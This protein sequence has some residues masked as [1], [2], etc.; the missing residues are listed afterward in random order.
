V[1]I[2]PSDILLWKVD[3]ESSLVDRIVGWAERKSGQPS[4][5]GTQFYHVGIIGPD[6]LHYYDSAPGGIKNSIISAIWPDHLQVYRF[7]K[8]VTPDQ[9]KLMWS[10]ANSQIGVGYNW[11]GAL[12]LGWIEVAG[13]PF[14][15]EFVWRVC[16]YAG[17]VICPWQTFLS[18]DDIAVSSMLRRVNY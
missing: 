2:Q 10:Y 1:N 7:K 4:I 8:P 13:K 3:A 9:Q 12:T 5:D 14:C 17:I 15:S 6:A 16:T 11:I 18:P